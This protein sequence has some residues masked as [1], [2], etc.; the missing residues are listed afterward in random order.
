M[1]IRLVGSVGVVSILICAAVLGPHP[2]A[3]QEPGTAPPLVVT[4]FGDK[5][6][7]P[8]AGHRTSWGDPDLQ[9]A[10]S[11]DDTS[12]I[13]MSRRERGDQQLSRRLRAPRVAADVVDR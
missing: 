13:P 8:Y 1:A 10:W 4:A 11:S 9:G 5:P 12:G 7:P 3:S 2:I 6:A